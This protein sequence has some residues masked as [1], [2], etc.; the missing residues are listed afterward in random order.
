M[1]LDYLHVIVGRRVMVLRGPRKGQEA[2]IKAIQPVGQS[3]SADC[4]NENGA[5]FLVSPMDFALQPT[6]SA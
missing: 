5:R 2:T 1:N 6:E 4:Y 3:W